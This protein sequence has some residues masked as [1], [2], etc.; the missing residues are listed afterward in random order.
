MQNEFFAV[1][2]ARY[3]GLFCVLFDLFTLSSRREENG[4]RF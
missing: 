2:G 3:L 1:K 4:F